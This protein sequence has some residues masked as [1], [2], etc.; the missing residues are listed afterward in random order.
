MLPV[1]TAVVATIGPATVRPIVTRLIGGAP[2]G[3][4]Q[5]LDLRHEYVVPDGDALPPLYQAVTPASFV[6]G[7]TRLSFSYRQPLGAHESEY[8][9]FHDGTM[10][11]RLLY[12]LWPLREWKHAPG[13][14]IA[15]RIEM[16]RNPPGW[17]KRTFGH[18]AD[19]S[20]DQLQ[21]HQAQVGQQLVYTATL[22]D[23]FPD[24]LRC[25]VGP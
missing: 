9:Y 24:Y 10:I 19:I 5:R 13:F 16:D 18:P 21:G 12:V 1:E 25:S 2:P 11:P 14:T 6:P 7:Q 8:S 15:L 3:F 4:A 17:W 23:D 22:T 20:C